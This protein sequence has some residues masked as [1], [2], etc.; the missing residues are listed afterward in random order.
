MKISVLIAT[1][2][3]RKTVLRTLEAL[4]AQAYPLALLH[5]TVLDDCGGDGTP[6]ALE[7]ARPGFLAR[8]LGGLK[9]LRNPV[10]M[11]IAYNRG[12]LSG[13]APPGDACLYLD[14]DVYLEKD[15][16][17]ALVDCLRRN[18]RCGLAGPRLV[19]ASD[20]A[21]TAHCANFVGRW[22]GRYTE[23]DAQD[24]TACDWLNSSC[25]LVRAEAG[26][27]AGHFAGFYMT[28]EE[29]DYCLQLKLAGWEVRYVPAVKALHDLPPAGKDRRKRLYYLYRNKLLVLRRNLPPLRA[30]T[31]LGTALLLGL[32]KYLL[33][34]LRYNGGVNLPELK[35]VVL[36]VLHGLA[37]RAG[38]L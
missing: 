11:G 2:D 29:V 28:H 22:T 25:F 34:S 37:G 5:V 30:F 33:E 23:L 10:N 7:A 14:D 38:K 1:R 19:Y 17:P 12:R 8:G 3:R 31:A 36:A 13:E 6:E 16:L 15:T 20:P 4:L 18:P 26:R 9:V 27:G 32:P 24:E 35:L 21:R